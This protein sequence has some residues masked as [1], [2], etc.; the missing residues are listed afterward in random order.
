MNK[1]ISDISW[2]ELKSIQDERG[3]LTVAEANS[4]I[5]F[6]IKRIFL[7]HNVVMDRGGHA[8][9]DTDQVLIAV[10]GSLTVRAYDGDIFRDFFL[11]DPSKGLLVPRMIFVDLINFSKDGVCLC[12]ANTHYDNSMSIRNL[13][14]FKKAIL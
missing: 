14:E 5:P 7:V 1:C 6:D 13:D 12:L 10:S 3:C 11:N 8:H 9:R 2:I 4:I